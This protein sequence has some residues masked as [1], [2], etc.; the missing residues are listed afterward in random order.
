MPGAAT[1]S[2][3]GKDSPSASE[4]P[5]ISVPF[6]VDPEEM[7]PTIPTGRGWWDNCDAWDKLN[8]LA[9]WD[10]L[11][12]YMD[13]VGELIEEFLKENSRVSSGLSPDSLTR[14]RQEAARASTQ[15]SM[16]GG[17]TNGFVRTSRANKID[18]DT[19]G[20]FDDSVPFRLPPSARA[21]PKLDAANRRAL[22][23]IEG[24]ARA[25]GGRGPSGS[26]SPNYAPTPSY[27]G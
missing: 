19:G 17:G 10:E 16:T 18:W 20:E 25:A 3:R 2:T 4:S 6:T 27:G 26:P 9:R 15:V 24:K 7:F 21:S 12:G 23:N 14:Q 11:Q 5:T 13:V 8:G 1:G 22:G